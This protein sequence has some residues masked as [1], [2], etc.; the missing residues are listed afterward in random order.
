MRKWKCEV[1]GYIHTGDSP[2]DK[3][4]VCGAGKSRFTEI[5]ETDAAPTAGAAQPETPAAAATEPET[6]ALQTAFDTLLGLV[7]KHKARSH[8]CL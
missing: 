3:C 6:P 1:C 2:P 4:P 8:P 7:V 5:T